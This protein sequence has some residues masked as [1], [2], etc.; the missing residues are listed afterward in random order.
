MRDI[1]LARQI[2]RNYKKDSFIDEQGLQDVMQIVTW[3][4]RIELEKLGIDVD[5][6]LEK[7]IPSHSHS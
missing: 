7:L 4:I 6:V 1:I 5:E 3:L 2:W